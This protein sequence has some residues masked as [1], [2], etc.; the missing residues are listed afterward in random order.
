VC[1]ENYGYY[2]YHR[3]PAGTVIQPEQGTVHA[4]TPTSQS[5]AGGQG[6]IDTAATTLTL[7]GFT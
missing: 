3:E 1:M 5:G 6:C 2:A 7:T 4:T